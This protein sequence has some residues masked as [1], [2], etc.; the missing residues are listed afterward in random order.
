MIEAVPFITAPFPPHNYSVKYTLNPIMTTTYGYQPYRDMGA[1]LQP[2]Q[3]PQPHRHA[4]S[5][6]YGGHEQLFSYEQPP[7][8][9]PQYSQQYDPAYMAPP[10][11]FAQQPVQPVVQQDEAVT[12]GVCPVLDY[13]LDI[14]TK[15]IAYLTHRL[16]NRR[17]TENPRFISQMKGVLGAVRL[18]K[19]SLIL[20][21]YFLLERFE[22]DNG[23]FASSATDSVIYETAVLSLVLSNKAND[24]HT[25]INKS[26]SDATGLQLRLI[27]SLEASWLR[28]LEWRLH[29]VRMPRYDELTVQFHKYTVNVNKHQ[30]K[31]QFEQ[32]QQQQQHQQYVAAAAAA[33]SA[34]QYGYARGA[35][36]PILSDRSE[37]SPRYNNVSYQSPCHYQQM[38]NSAGFTS[39]NNNTGYHPIHQKS[40]SLQL[41]QNDF[42]CSKMGFHNKN[43]FCSCNFCSTPMTSSR[44]FEWSSRLGT[45]C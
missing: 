35:I 13:D 5:Y 42:G 41:D 34:N 29:D 33:A 43:Q 11:Y 14:M 45:A 23:M 30:A 44:G 12:G 24:D 36:S 1:A 15:F 10:Q 26:W 9:V 7:V 25:F 32:Q 39:T 8:Y 16:F 27:N 20:A 21:C 3:Q 2:Q 19:S 18:P 28:V 22:K 17:D 4:H 40:Y 37:F 6:S 31:I 38:Y